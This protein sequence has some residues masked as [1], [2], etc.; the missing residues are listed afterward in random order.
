[1][2]SYASINGV[3]S[4]ANNLLL[5]NIVRGQWKRDMVT[6]GTDCGAI[7]NMVNAN[8]YARDPVDAVAKTLN[9][10]ADMELGE[11]Y[12]TTNGYLEQAVQQNRTTIN[13]VNNAVRRVLYIRFITGQFDPIDATPYTSIGLDGINSARHQQINFEA[14]IQGLVLLKNDDRALPLSTATKV[15]V[16]GPHSI[17][18]GS[19]LSDY[20]GDQQCFSGSDD[21]IPTI[22]EWITKVNTNGHTRVQQGV[23][24]N[25][26]NTSGIQAALDAVS[27]SDVVVLCLG[28]DRSVE[29]EGIDRTSTDLPGLQTSFAQQVLKTAGNKR[30][31]LVLINGGALSIDGLTKGPAAIVEAFYPALRGAEALARTLFGEHNRFGKLPYTIY[32]SSFQQECELTD[33]QMSPHANCKGRTYRYY[34]G[35]PLYPFGF[36][37]SYTSFDASCSANTTRSVPVQVKCTVTNKDQHQAG[38][39]VIMVYH[40]VSAAIRAAA[41]HPIPNRA[42]VGFER[43]SLAPSQTQ[44]IEFT[45]STDA[46]E[47][48]TTSGGQKL[49]SG[50]HSLIFTNGNTFEQVL[51]FSIDG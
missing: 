14:A 13:T 16:V 25:S 17:T 24:I 9:G 40:N 38:D 20:A 19:L 49:Y 35:Q 23:D 29:H 27:T 8:K 37:L 30:V 42:L 39:E 5:N 44:T 41:P 31:I 45:L 33:M 43:V 11:T 3:P 48:T 22:G 46:F 10:G 34:M 12:F 18:R 47:V 4:C 1:M 2:C 15:A 21:C 26:Q 36:G 28:I 51:Q 50:S 6:I 7:A 32:S